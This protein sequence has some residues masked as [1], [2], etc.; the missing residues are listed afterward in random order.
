MIL[1]WEVVLELKGRMDSWYAKKNSQEI[2]ENREAKFGL[3]ICLDFLRFLSSIFDP[4]C[5]KDLYNV[6]LIW[7]LK[8]LSDNI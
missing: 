1:L 4:H 5:E 6:F 2:L 8:G 7:L 3:V